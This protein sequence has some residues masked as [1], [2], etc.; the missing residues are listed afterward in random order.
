MGAGAHPRWRR[1][2][3]DWRLEFV[4]HGSR[5]V[6][7]AFPAADVLHH[8]FCCC[9]KLAPRPASQRLPGTDVGGLDV[10]QAAFSVV[11]DHGIDASTS[12]LSSPSL[13]G[14]FCDVVL[15]RQSHA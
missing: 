15:P 12:H 13:S 7:T 10:V 4:G 2:D 3:P 9:A 8:Q 14:V 5:G 1:S 6:G 11:A